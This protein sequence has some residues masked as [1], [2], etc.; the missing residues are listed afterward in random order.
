MS[1]GTTTFAVARRSALAGLVAAAV[2]LPTG[3]AAGSGAA[4]PRGLEP[5]L[6]A[7]LEVTG[8]ATDVPIIVRF[9]GLRPLL[10]RHGAGATPRGAV[11]AELRARAERAW[12]EVAPLADAGGARHVRLLWGAGGV[13][14]SGRPFLIRQLATHPAVASVA[15]DRSWTLRPAPRPDPPGDPSWNLDAIGAAALWG[16]GLTGEGTVVAILDTG[17]DA[18]HPDLAAS[19][20]GAPGGWLDPAG[21]HV[22][23][24]DLDGHGTRA[25]GL[26]VGGA[27]SGTTIGAAP[28]ARWIAAKI[29]DDAGGTSLGAIHA[30]LQWLLDPD[31]DPDTD[32]SPDIVSN[33]WGLSGLP[34][35]CDDEFD[36]DLEALRA[37]GIVVVFAAGNDG[38]AVGSSIIPANAPGVLSVGAVDESL[39]LLDASGRGPSACGG[40]T[41]PTVVA[42]GDGLS[43]TDL[44]LGG[45]VPQSYA[46]VTGTSFAAPQVAGVAALLRQACPAAPASAIEAAL[47]ATAVDLG[48]AGPDNGFGAGLVD[49]AGAWVALLGS[50]A[51][52]ETVADGGVGEDAG[53]PGVDGGAP[54]GGDGNGGTPEGEGGAERDGPSA[55]PEG[56]AAPGE[57]CSAA[58][59]QGRQRRA[60]VFFVVLA[61]LA[62]P[63][64]ARRHRSGMIRW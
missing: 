64:G 57:G 12:R 48:P 19:W 26:L 30:S 6:A 5:L 4:R 8:A 3:A 24:A 46:S 40:G 51:C 35:E 49:A 32:D 10:A 14:L 56:R 50:S 38:P 53:R 21:Q 58:G 16:Q 59:P 45:V 18:Q 22:S 47:G 62:V 39:A 7:R 1:S 55:S 34:G 20:R 9:A 28:G 25:L 52:A 36:A 43:T 54:G 29:F 17:V 37:A 63:A 13:A 27:A 11:I 42:P 2:T 61:L 33:S 60:G 15:L 44:T 23:P 31:G 41:Y